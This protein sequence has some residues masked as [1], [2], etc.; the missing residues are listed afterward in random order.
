MDTPLNQIEDLYDDF[1]LTKLPLMEQEVRGTK[2]ISKFS[3]FLIKP[4]NPAVHKLT[5]DD[6]GD[7]GDDG[8]R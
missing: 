4:F 2:S 8:A 7:K 6:D 5:L 3:K 1:H